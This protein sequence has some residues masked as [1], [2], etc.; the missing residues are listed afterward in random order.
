MHALL[1]LSALFIIFGSLYPF[2]IDLALWSSRHLS[3]FDG[4]ETMADIIGNIVL[5]I[6]FGFAA[7]S[8][9]R[10]L[11][12]ALVGIAIALLVQL[13]QIVIPDRSP[14]VWDVVNNVVGLAIGWVLA[15][16]FR[17][18]KR[19]APLHPGVFVALLFF[20]AF[21]LAP[22]APTLDLG[23]LRANL[24]L[25][26]LAHVEADDAVRAALQAVVLAVVLALE[27]PASRVRIALF[28][29]LPALGVARLFVI[30][31]GVAPGTIAGL[32]AAAVIILPLPLA[33]RWMRLA[34]FA[35]AAVLTLDAGLAPMAGNHAPG[36][37]PFAGLVSKGGVRVLAAVLLK[38]F[39]YASLLEIGRREFGRAAALVAVALALV[40][41]LLLAFG[42]PGTSPGT[43]DLVLA[44]LLAWLFTR[45]GGGAAR[46]PLP[47][48]PSRR[49]R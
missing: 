13:A 6:P 26:V 28:L 24:K 47:V 21:Q 35:A 30:D 44:A 14:S 1:I 23:L 46:R 42:W 40:V 29:A 11:A 27:L 32:A 41:D 36:L 3:G 7:R 4:H 17:D 37:L 9:R 38:V 18:R 5:F 2:D 12:F 20:I 19:P 33:A 34:A 16:P 31:N 48:R 43:T 45:F 49:R 8:L 39:L 22:F 15:L 10:P 25:F